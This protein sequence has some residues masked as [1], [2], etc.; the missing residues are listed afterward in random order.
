MFRRIMI[1]IKLNKNDSSG[2]N[3]DW[4]SIRPFGKNHVGNI[5]NLE[6]LLLSLK[7]ILSWVYES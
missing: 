7:L 6:T 2:K 4:I 1:Y 5:G 3:P